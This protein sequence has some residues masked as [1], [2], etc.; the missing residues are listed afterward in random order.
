[1]Q[2]TG[3]A[4]C[5]KEFGFDCDSEAGAAFR[6]K[7]SYGVELNASPLLGSSS[8]SSTLPLMMILL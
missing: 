4:K 5:L 7:K 1:M 6:M 8:S 3:P 2:L